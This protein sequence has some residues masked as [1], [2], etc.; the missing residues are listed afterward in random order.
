MK[1]KINLDYK[2]FL[3]KHLSNLIIQKNKKILIVGSSGF[4]GQNLVLSLLNKNSKKK[5]KIYGI[6]ISKKKVI[7]KNFF[8][9]KIDLYKYKKKAFSLMK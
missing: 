7:D 6:D 4:I 9:K 2:K 8:Y 5:N 1:D 3:D